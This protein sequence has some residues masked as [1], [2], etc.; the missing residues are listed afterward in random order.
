M[1]IADCYD[2]DTDGQTYRGDVATTVSGLECQDWKAHYPQKHI[3]TDSV[4]FNE[5]GISIEDNHCRNPEG[6]GDRP[7]CYAV[8]PDIRWQ[9]CN[10]PRCGGELTPANITVPPDQHVD[11]LVGEN[12]TL[13]CWAT[14]LPLPT[15]Q[16]SFPSHL[17]GRVSIQSNGGFSRLS[18]VSA[19]V[20]DMGVFT[21]TAS[22]EG[23]SPSGRSVS[24]VSNVNV[25]GELLSAV[26]CQFA[27]CMPLC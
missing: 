5:L 20:A 10:V 9:Y 8:D 19:I 12:I 16:W 3:L 14:G 25:I 22:N 7:W 1:S 13:E 17:S 15:I 4:D 6:R 26:C 18:V 23:M 21:C 11:V 27:C 24:A 2:D